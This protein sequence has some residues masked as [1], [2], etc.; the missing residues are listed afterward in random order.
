[1]DT[2][3]TQNPKTQTNTDSVKKQ[4]IKALKEEFDK[5]LEEIY[6][7][8]LDKLDEIVKG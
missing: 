3:T 8:F 1:M 4:D 2:A 7:K 5:D 6:L